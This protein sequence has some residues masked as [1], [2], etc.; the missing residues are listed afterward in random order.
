MKGLMHRF[1]ILISLMILTGC[2]NQPVADSS[3]PDLKRSVGQDV[4]LSGKFELYGKAGPYIYC[5]GQPVYLV[6]QGSYKWGSQYDAMEG[7]E[8]S[9]SGVLHFRHFEPV[10][11][12]DAVQQTPDYFYFDAETAKVSL[13]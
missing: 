8:V 7:K 6:P 13:K 11:T 10:R 4:T 3:A 5:N 9:F 12:S 2:A 1:L